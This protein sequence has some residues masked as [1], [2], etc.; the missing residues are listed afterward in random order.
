VRKIERERKETGL[1]RDGIAERI[2]LVTVQSHVFSLLET[3][4]KELKILQN[5]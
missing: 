1:D 2:E 3:D 4:I 5:L